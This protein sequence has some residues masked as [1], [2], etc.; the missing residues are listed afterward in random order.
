MNLLIL[1]MRRKPFVSLLLI[2]L[3]SVGAALGSVGVSAYFAANRQTE[4]AADFYTTVAIPYD[5]VWLGRTPTES[6]DYLRDPQALYYDLDEILSDLPVSALPCAA[7][8][9]QGIIP[10]SVNVKPHDFDSVFQLWG[11]SVTNGPD[12]TFVAAARCDSVTDR[13]EERIYT[14]WDGDV[15]T[16]T[17]TEKEKSCSYVFS[18]TDPICMPEPSKN[19]YQAKYL[20]LHTRIY[21]QDGS[22]LFEKGKTY[23]LWGRLILPLREWAEDGEDTPA[24]YTLFIKE[25]DARSEVHQNGAV[26]MTYD[27]AYP[28]AAQFSGSVQDF[29]N[30]EEGRVWR[31]ELIPAAERN[32]HCVMLLAVDCAESLAPF[33]ERLAELVA[34]RFY[35]SEEAASGAKVCLVSAAWAEKNGVSVGDVLPVAVYAPQIEVLQFVGTF[36]G[37]GYA[38]PETDGAFLEMRPSFASDDTGQG[39]DYEVVGIYTC[40]PSDHGSL[41][42]GPDTVLIPKSSIGNADRY[43]TE[44]MTHYPLLN[45]YLLPDGAQEEME[46]A[47][48]ECGFAGNFLYYDYGFSIAKDAIGQMS[49]NG[50]YLLCAGVAA[51]VLS[52]LLFVLLQ[53]LLLARSIRSMRLIGQT[54]AAIRRSFAETIP[55]WSVPAVLLGGL[56]A[57]IGYGLVT[58]KLFSAVLSYDYGIAGLAALFELLVICAAL[59]IAGACASELR[60]MRGGRR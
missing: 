51:F 48:A 38:G 33:C 29:L 2:L 9:L 45:A 35:T 31:E 56:F 57:R 47:L 46:Q 60:L 41:R 11:Y 14:S 37:T 16:G 32:H 20:E 34:G 22:A 43:R 10:D 15:M 3:L 6:Y 21:R 58:K 1:W 49:D 26:W 17:W 28:M 25:Y 36:D 39:G 44:A 59:W 30:S 24:A 42:F 4:T 50:T 5:P 55:L 18:V 27:E 53:Q 13:S 19:E 54:P 8:P 23:L 12:Y 40:P 52:V 7:V